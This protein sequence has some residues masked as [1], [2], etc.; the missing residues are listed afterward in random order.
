MPTASRRDPGPRPATAATSSPPSTPWASP[1]HWEVG[2]H[3]VNLTN[4]DK[5]LWPGPGYT[6]RDLVRYYATIA[7]VDPA[8]PARPGPQH[9]P[10]ARRHHRSSLL[11]EADPLARARLGRALGLPRGGQGPVAHLRRRRPG[12]DHGLAGQ[13][14]GHRPPPLDVP[15]AGLHAARP[16]RSSTSTRASARPGTRCWCWRVCTGPRSR[17]WASAATPRRPASAASRSG[18]R[19][20]RAT[21]GTRRSTGWRGC[22]GPWAP[23]SPTWSAGTGPRPTGAA[24][25]A[26]TTPRTR[27]SRRSWRRTRC[28][29]WPRPGCRRPSPGTSWRTRSS[30]PTAGTCARC[31]PGWRRS[32]T[33]SRGRWCSTR[34]LP[35]L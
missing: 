2:G 11:A 25:R 10:L 6:K 21:P 22:R 35:S 4:L 32:A 7:P 15:A 34:T 17:T 13:P 27:P 30:G 31:P 33:C 29:P 14:G 28:D 19:S 23:P 26:S 5:V 9:R 3:T 8:L 1:G 20:R 24:G 12:G 18:C 16:T